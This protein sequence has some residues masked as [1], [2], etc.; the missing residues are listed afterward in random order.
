MVELT[1]SA[2]KVKL[3]SISFTSANSEKGGELTPMHDQP[4]QIDTRLH[5][6]IEASRDLPGGH[7]VCADQTM[8]LFEAAG[9][10]DNTYYWTIADAK[11]MLQ[12]LKRL[13]GSATITQPTP[14]L[15]SEWEVHALIR[16]LEQALREKL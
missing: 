4:I 7:C 10:R 9:Y 15:L 16:D 8:Y 12:A 14:E 13:A 2:G 5:V 6:A 1:S 3:T 11:G